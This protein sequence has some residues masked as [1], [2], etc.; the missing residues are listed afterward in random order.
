M[1]NFFKKD[2]VLHCYTADASVYNYAPI[3]K[4]A[5]FLPEWWRKLPK[6]VPDTG[7][8]RVVPIS[9]MKHCAGFTGIYSKGFILPLWCDLN[10]IIGGLQDPDIPG[11]DEYYYQFSDLRS[12]IM[13]HL[14]EQHVGVY[15]TN[16]Y[17]HLK[18]MSPWVIRCEE[19]IDF[20]VIQ[21]TWNFNT[22][23]YMFI[24]PGT[25]NFKH[26]T[27][28]HIN[29]F[30]KRDKEQKL[31][32][33]TFGQPLMH[34]IPLT[35]RKIQLQHHLVSVEELNRVISINTATSFT[36]K[37]KRNIN[38]LKKNNCPYKIDVEK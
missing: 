18:I 9:T 29:F 36:N 7:K 33:L 13:T 5:N 30:W 1:F 17:Q 6:L 28:T 3:Q 19:D 24:P 23:E 38:R 15:P 32:N 37:Y 31:H 25:L 8:K 12:E 27:N 2:L 35:E 20:A 11:Q 26:Q 10:L 14:E 21:P 16:A 22:P 34:F 4:A